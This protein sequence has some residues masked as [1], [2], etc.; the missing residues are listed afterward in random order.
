MAIEIKMDEKD[1]E[2]FLCK[3]GN[4]QKYID[5][6]LI[7]LERQFP[8]T[9]Y[10][11]ST[12]SQIRTY[13]I[14]ILAWNKW[15]KQLVVIELKKDDID[16]HAINQS[17]RYKRILEGSELCVD[18]VNKLLM[19]GDCTCFS[20]FSVEEDGA[21]K[22][23]QVLIIGQHLDNDVVHSLDYWEE[24]AD[25]G[26]RLFSFSLE[27]TIEF[28]YYTPEN[29]EC[30]YGRKEIRY[31]RFSILRSVIED[32][33]SL[34]KFVDTNK[35][36]FPESCPGAIKAISAIRGICKTLPKYQDGDNK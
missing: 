11:N 1:L 2:D 14:D 8:V 36:I 24:S 26:Y 17:L 28:N 35:N 3:E 32:I 15:S 34:R 13:Y 20:K 25:I 10:N 6:N 27:K 22:K 31:E 5:K 23:V 16:T 7:L 30:S 9:V 19:V 4:L 12:G 29:K 21:Q 18:W 33:K